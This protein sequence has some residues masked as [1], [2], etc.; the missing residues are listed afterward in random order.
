[1]FFPPHPVFS[2]NDEKKTCLTCNNLTSPY[3]KAPKHGL[4]HKTRKIRRNVVYVIKKKRGLSSILNCLEFFGEGVCVIALQSGKERLQKG[5][6]AAGSRVCTLARGTRDAALTRDGHPTAVASPPPLQASRLLSIPHF[7]SPGNST[8]VVAL[9]PP[10]S[11]PEALALPFRTRNPPNLG[12][13]PLRRAL[14]PSFPR[15]LQSC[16]LGGSAL[17]FGVRMRGVW[18]GSG[19]MACP[20]RPRRPRR[21]FLLSATPPPRLS[22]RPLALMKIFSLE[23]PSF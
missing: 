16:N 6:R 1:M 9:C 7:L 21:P 12:W 13:T 11:L 2:K 19:R 14:P 23:S 17:N 8:A 4:K 20:R 22:L 18:E 15:P 3:M 10:P 5:Q